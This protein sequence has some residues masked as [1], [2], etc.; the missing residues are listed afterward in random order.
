MDLLTWRGRVSTWLNRRRSATYILATERGLRPSHPHPTA[1]V[2]LGGGARGAT[3]A[4]A[5]R[6]ILEHGIVPNY[7]VSISAGS[8]NG[9]LLAQ[10]P[11][12]ERAREPKRP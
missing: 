1:F 10:D 9:A 12:P 7:I 6:V 8:W 2:L 4:G 11:P 3:Q 5:L